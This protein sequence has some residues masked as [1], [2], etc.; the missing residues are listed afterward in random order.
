MRSLPSWVKPACC[1]SLLF[2]GVSTAAAAHEGWGIVSDPRGHIFFTDTARQIVWR[3]D[4][5]GTREAVLEGTHSHALVSIGTGSVYGV[6]AHLTEP[7]GS[8]WRID[9]SGDVHTL[10]PPTRDLPLG[11]HS[12][13]IDADGTMYSAIRWAPEGKVSLLRRRPDGIAE[14]VASGFQGIDGMTWAPDGAILLTDGPLLKRVAPDGTVEVLGGGPLTDTRWDADL[15]GVATD[16]SGGAFVADFSNGRILAVGRRSGVAQEYASA[17]P[18]SPTGIA[19]DA[20]G[21]LVLEYLEMPW[22]LLG[23]LQVGPYL[24]VRRLGV[25]G[26]VVTLAVLWGT[27]T[28]VAAAGLVLL[29]VAV[30]GR[31]LRGYHLAAAD[32]HTQTI[33]TDDQNSP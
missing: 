31:Q 33:T 3:L 17:F 14:R 26:R 20:N 22:G 13:L 21:L 19:R 23:N 7:V 4:S 9:A 18:W 29:V 24:R 30:I 15:M 32:D 27:R 6:H 8:V 10:L 5:D 11:L 2:L 25:K 1:I 28:R 16:G 12:F